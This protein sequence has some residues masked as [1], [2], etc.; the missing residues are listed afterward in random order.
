MTTASA[1]SWLFVPAATPRRFERA[2]GSGADAVI[3]DLEDAVAVDAKD[4][5]RGDAAAWL[6]DGGQ[7]W[8]RINAHGTPWHEEDVATLCD[9]P[10]LLGLVA[11]KVEDPRVLG[12]LTARLG[13][14]KALVALVET[15]RG[16]QGVAD[17]AGT[18]RVQRLA[19]GSLDFALD[20][21]AEHDDQSLLLARSSLVLASRAAGLPPPIDGVT[22]TVHDADAVTADARRARVLGF[23]GKLCIHPAQVEPVARAFAPTNEELA[24]ARD[25]HR[26]AE[27]SGGGAFLG[28]DG[29]MVD[30]PVID[31]AAAILGQAL[32]R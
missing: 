28:P 3:L 12:R 32:S 6:A 17:I 16:V 29:Q 21:G 23:G 24:W 8:V 25:V 26:A 15:A 9:L 27:R 18:P 14:G 7:A 10:G 30:R 11:P 20:I 2:V 4:T 31:R 19:F 5:A 22:T 13:P 1:A